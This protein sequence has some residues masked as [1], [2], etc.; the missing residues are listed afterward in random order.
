MNDIMEVY[1]FLNQRDIELTSKESAGML[2]T[3]TQLPEI[4]QVNSSKDLVA[5]IA[6]ISLVI[7][8]MADKKMQHL[9]LMVD[10]QRYGRGGVIVLWV[11]TFIDLLWS[12]T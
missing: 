12:R 7:E 5:M 6:S 9:L 3:S 8:K 4:L 11:S 2:M 10:S 1:E